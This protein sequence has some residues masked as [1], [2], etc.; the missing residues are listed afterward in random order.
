MTARS[1]G[2]GIGRATVLTIMAGWRGHPQANNVG[3]GSVTVQLLADD[4]ASVVKIAPD[5]AKIDDTPSV[6]DLQLRYERGRIYA[7]E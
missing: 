6:G 2:F 1:G 7:E 5:R 3:D 4:E